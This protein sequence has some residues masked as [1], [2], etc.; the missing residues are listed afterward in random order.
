MIVCVC[1]RV[2]D[3]QL[4]EAIRNGCRDLRSLVKETCAGTDCASCIGDLRSL[5]QQEAPSAI[6]TGEQAPGLAAK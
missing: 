4:R 1:K 6:G 5:L 2:N 3:H